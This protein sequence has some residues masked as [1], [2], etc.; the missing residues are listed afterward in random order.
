M[1]HSA[2]PFALDGLG[3]VLAAAALTV[4][5]YVIHPWAALVPGLLT[6][7]L[8][9]FFRSP[10]RRVVP[11][12]GVLLSPADGKVMSVVPVE[13]D[14][15]LEGPAIRISIFLSVFDVHINR[16]PCSGTVTHVEYREGKFLP[17]F[18]SHASELNERNAVVIDCDDARGR[19]RVNQVTGMLA[20]RIVCDVRKGD[21]VRQGFRF[22]MIKLGSCTELIVP[23]GCTVDVEPGRTVRA[24][25][26]V[27]ARW[28]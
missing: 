25:I 24:G 19:V 11:D 21:T 27:L 13:F 7:F 17:A 23:S 2:F 3:V 20:R 5:L 28:P 1:R 10:R 14:P 6:L 26:T 4:I 8:L 12:P 22:G 15:M 9:W 16:A 18:K